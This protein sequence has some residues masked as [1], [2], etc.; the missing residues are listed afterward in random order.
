MSKTGCVRG[1]QDERGRGRDGTVLGFIPCHRV[2]SAE[3]RTNL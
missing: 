3:V 1:A 2:A